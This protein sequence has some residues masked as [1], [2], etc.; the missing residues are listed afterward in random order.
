MGGALSVFDY[1]VAAGLCVGI[2]TGVAVFVFGHWFP[3]LRGMVVMNAITTSAT[4]LGMAWGTWWRPDSA[5]E[6]EDKRAFFR[7]LTTES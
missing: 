4:P 5:E 1:V 7:K 3:C 2:G 6:R